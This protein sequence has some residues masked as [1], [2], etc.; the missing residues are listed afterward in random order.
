[1]CDG[2]TR[3]AFKE[4]ATAVFMEAESIALFDERNSLE[5]MTDT[6]AGGQIPAIRATHSLLVIYATNSAAKVAF[7]PF[8]AA[9]IAAYPSI[10]EAPFGPF[11]M[12]AIPH[13]H[14]TSANLETRETCA[15]VIAALP[16]KKSL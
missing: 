11:G 2:K 3:P 1:M 12:G 8:A 10:G 7:L 5:S 14:D 13:F 15:T 6:R 16:A 9:P 4:S